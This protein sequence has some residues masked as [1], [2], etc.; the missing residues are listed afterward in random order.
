M[1]VGA[2]FAA[3]GIVVNGL[4]LYEWVASDFGVVS[5]EITS[6]VMLGATLIL[7]GVQIVFGAFFLGVLRGVL[8][9]VWVD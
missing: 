5:R 7:V 1:I 6:L 4:I 2:V 8:T 3:V 9:D